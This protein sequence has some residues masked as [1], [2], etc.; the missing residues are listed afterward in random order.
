MESVYVLIRV[1][2]TFEQVVGEHIQKL[3]SCKEI[4]P[5][6]GEYDYMAKIEG[7]DHAEITRVILSDIR[8]LPGVASTKTLVKTSF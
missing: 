7:A 4:H 1:K 5:L 3:K 8:G 2:P 6:F